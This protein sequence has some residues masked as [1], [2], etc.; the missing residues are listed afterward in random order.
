[1]VDFIKAVIPPNHIPLLLENEYLEFKQELNNRTGELSKKQ[2][3]KYN[4]LKFTVFADNYAEISGSLHKFFNGGLHNADE[5]GL[6]DLLTVLNQIESLFKIDLGRYKLSNIEIGVN[7]PIS[8]KASQI[9][10]YLLIHQTVRFKDVSL[11]NG[12]YKQATHSQYLVKIYDKGKQYRREF[13]Q[14]QNELLRFELKYFKMQKL[15]DR[16]IFVLNDLFD[17]DN[18]AF[19]FDLLEIAWDETLLYD[20]TIQK[21]KLTPYVVLKKLNQ[22]QNVNYWLELTKQRRY[23]VRKAYHSLVEDHSDN[24]HSKIGRDIKN[25]WFEL[26]NNSLPIYRIINKHFITILP[27]NYN[28]R[29]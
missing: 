1:M 2:V 9:L 19:I 20:K 11:I 6:L 10:N 16:G 17:T 8:F 15:N 29:K 7:I 28:V 26:V 4:D 25:K 21:S 5:F 23:E 27:F 3:A 13:P 12:N 14:F 18:L 24:R 22:W